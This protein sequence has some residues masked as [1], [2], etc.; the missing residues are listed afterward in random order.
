MSIPAV[1]LRQTAAEKMN[2]MVSATVITTFGAQV[3]KKD[4]WLLI[5]GLIALLVLAQRVALL[6]EVLAHPQRASSYIRL[7]RRKKAQKILSTRIEAIRYLLKGSSVI[8]YHYEKEGSSPSKLSSRLI[9][10][11][12]NG[13]PFEIFA[14]DNRYVFVSSHEHIKEMDRAPDTVLSLQA[15]S[16]Q[17]SPS[18]IEK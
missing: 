7:T 1:D 11:Q 4:H 18:T 12:S 13:K 3:E 5:I 17:V 14:P 8:Q 9:I 16:K 15:A 10:A 6:R 2:L